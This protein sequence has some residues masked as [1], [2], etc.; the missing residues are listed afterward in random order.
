MTDANHW[1]VSDDLG[2][3]TYFQVGDGHRARLK[4]T[5]VTLK[6]QGVFRCRVDFVDSPTRNFRVNLTLV[7]NYHVFKSVTRERIE[8]HYTIIFLT[9][10]EQP[11][12]PV[13]YDA[14]GREVTGVGGPFLEGYSL[15]LTCQVSGGIKPAIL[16]S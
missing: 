13:I 7:G 2:G 9:F 11:S 1:A 10:S 3:R 8:Y 4:V 15:A 14:Q 16:S 5:K 6:D 12:T